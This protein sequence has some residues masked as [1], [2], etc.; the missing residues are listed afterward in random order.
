MRPV[1]WAVLLIA[2]VAVS[3]FT[4]DDESGLAVA[5]G[6]TSSHHAITAPSP[7]EGYW[8]ASSDGQVFA[9][10]DAPFYG[11]VGTTA[12]N[13]PVVAMASTPD[14]GG[15]WLVASD[16]GIFNY[17]DAPFYGSTGGITLNKPVVAVAATPDGA[18]YWLVASDGGIFAYGDAPF[19]GSTGGMTL[20]K[21]VVAMAATPDGKGYW[22]VAS[23]GGIFAY[24]DAPFYGSTGAMT[25]NKPVV[26]MAATPDGKGYWLVSSDGGIFA[27]G[28]APFYGS[29]G[30]ITL[31]KPVVAM[32]ATSDG[33]GYWLV[34]SDGGIFAYGN[35]PFDG[36]AGALALNEPVVAMARR[37]SPLRRS[38][39][40]N[41]TNEVAPSAPGG[42]RASAASSSSLH[43]AWS[44][45]TTAQAGGV[46]VATYTL[47]CS[48]SGCSTSQ[49]VSPANGSTTSVTLSGLAASTMYDLTLT[50]TNQNDLT[51]PP[52][53]TSAATQATSPTPSSITTQQ[54]ASGTGEGSLI[55]GPSGTVTDT[56][57]V[58]GNSSTGAPTGTVTFTECG[59]GTSTEPCTSGTSLGSAVSLTSTS[60][61]T[62]SATSA[63][64]T[65]TAVGTYC[66]AALY[67]PASGSNYSGSSDNMGT[68]ADPNECVSVTP[69]STTT[70][71]QQSANSSGEGSIVIGP[72]GTVTDTATVSG[73]TTAGAP[74]GTVTFTV[75]GPGTSTQPCTSGTSLGSA[76]S[77]T[78]KSSS[79]S[80]AT[81]A[82]FTPTAVG[83]Y[84]FAALYTPA[85]G[86][87]YSG[88]SDN[89]GT[90]ADA[91]E[92]VS[93]T[94]A[95]SSTT[96]QQSASGTGEGSLIIGPSG[97]VTD[98]A[99]VTGN[100][101][102]GAPTG[103][104][105]FT[106]CGPSLSTQPCTSGTSLGSAVSLTSK[107]SSTSG[108]TSASFTPTA[109]GTYC[110]AAL[111]TP[112]SGSNYSG[113]SDNMGTSADANEC[114]TAGN[115]P[116]SIT[117][118]QSASG[119]G[120]GSLIIGPSGT[121][122]DT[123]TVMG[124]SSTGAP[125]GTVTFTECGPGTS[126]EPCTSGTSLGSAVSLTSTSSSTSSATS[127]SFTPTA[128]GT[129][130][131]A[132]LYTPA[133]GSNYSGSSDN[134]G[135]S[136]DPNE[137]VSVTPASTTTSTQQS[138]NSSGEG[139][140][141]IGPSG[142][143][144]DTATVSGNTTAG[145]PTGTVTFTVC[146]PGTSTQPCTSGT[147][148]GS[149]V[150]L[151][152]KS[153]STSGATSASFT[154][155]AVG[156]Y[157]F[158]ALY[159]P[160][161]GSNYSGSSD[162]MGTS[163]DANECV[164]VTPAPSSTTTQQSASGTGEGSLI[165]GPSG[166]VT[167]TATVTGNAT[168]G[169]P[170]GTVTFTVCGPSLSTQPC[171]SG[172]S[173]GSAVSLTS[174]SSSTSGATSASF[175]PTAVGT[176]CFAALYTPASGSNY[177]G[178]S[179][180]MGTSADANECVSVT[181]APSSTTTQQSASGTG[182]GSL[183]IGPS[184]TVTDTATVTGNATTGAP[185]GTVTFT[186]CGPS[187]STQPCTSGTSLGSAVS[188]TSKS[189][190][191]SGATSASF[192][193]TAVGTYC[194]AALYTPASGSNYSGSSDN[195]G[196]SADANECVTAG[197]T[198][199]SITTQQSASG[200]GE[201]SLIIGP[202]G[203]VTDT[204][205]VMGNSSTGA[206]T[207]TVTFTECGPGT[208]TEPCTSGTSL[209]SAVSL[210]S[211]SSSTS[212]ATS[213]SLTPTA[214]GTYCFAAL[215]TPASGSNYSGSSENMGTSADPNECVSVTPASGTWSCTS[216]EPIDDM[217]QAPTGYTGSTYYVYWENGICGRYSPDRTHF[218]GMTDTSGDYNETSEVDQDDWSPI[219]LNSSG[220]VV[221]VNDPTCV[222]STRQTQT[223]NSNSAQNF[224]VV[225][226]VPK[227][228]SGAVTTYPN[229]WA[230]GYQGTVV[231][232]LSSLTSTY[233]E[234]MPI[235]SST[236]AWAMQDDWLTAPGHPT[237][238]SDYE[239]MV[240]YDFTNNGAC[241]STWSPGNWGIVANNVMID[242]VAWH[243]CDGQAAHN[244]DG[245]CP[246][247]YPYCG[248][249]VFKLGA[250][251]A[252]KPSLTSTSGTL[253][254]KAMFQWLENHDVPGTS[255]PYI[256]PGS[257]IEALSQGWEIA[258]TGGVPETFDGNGFTVDAV[259]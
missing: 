242:G 185:T 207:G 30:G 82:S 221:G 56:A 258:S 102:T 161:I 130:C 15:Y 190:S 166:T 254:L 184:G 232:D 233:N 26:A 202:S 113:S 173:L 18:G 203:T 16:G 249:M 93:V 217:T 215:Y 105:T 234:T 6:A 243:V 77:L 133:S 139:S 92:C 62:S 214:V 193:P 8:L 181:P 43:V 188:L 206:P 119:T 109:V 52:S 209:G 255:Y 134:M 39:T 45:E 178:S 27:Y 140:I 213:A 194:F 31:N 95:P 22:L 24:G 205:T 1:R 44:N 125:T 216:N 129:Y 75:C 123:A 155:T 167:D 182:E 97:T 34:A 115:T 236:S 218:V 177:S 35:A 171:T 25:L 110:F 124:N 176:Y 70:S 248:A 19:Y 169:A 179:D 151:T 41:A 104:V 192:T 57:T 257:S 154:P 225:S 164:S 54:S 2:L 142:T 76:V 79:T 126:T 4:V 5:G 103:T 89:M 158:A 238:E 146:G 143:V 212:S 131:F 235:N 47:S 144:T 186:V 33:G 191:T 245:T 114:V 149:A 224:Q 81:S 21:P 237:G 36:S 11:S 137:C 231:D 159:T 55:I 136:A 152:S 118:Q 64:F 66:F 229:A 91:N 100:A 259:P 67:T 38:G 226:T 132:A 156:T 83:T 138:A 116:S 80:G 99:T 145:A 73:N 197:N 10:G 183:I 17:G 250:T 175:T 63:S 196:T 150:S 252:S 227:N 111:Y 40:V 84:C 121:V 230:H 157:C 9:Y 170:T 74:T 208:S 220:G 240:Q 42:L 68:S 241:P 204:A 28:D 20:N 108:A 59:P 58:M 3:A 48:G 117:T 244:S 49:S 29:T 72:S 13:K 78:S 195:M 88:S 135:T 23:D 172:T 90:S 246:T 251:E 239:V 46:A 222:A 163:A 228:T 165:I 200:T 98:T 106:V 127:A 53:T 37:G 141:V 65:P 210:T 71:T 223:I 160:A 219:C 199:S 87:N 180:N 85:I 86:S 120:E 61:S 96:T 187:L 32:A 12:L 201:G 247:T 168:T 107:S 189:S 50:A 60:S 69:A 7:G 253:D 51:G 128:V 14:G 174:K 256:Q 94:P 112:A 147:S 101:T 211:T 162:N 198:P 148:L 122:T 153:S